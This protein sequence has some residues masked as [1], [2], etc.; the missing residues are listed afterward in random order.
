MQDTMTAEELA[1]LDRQNREAEQHPGGPKEYWREQY[2]GDL[3]GLDRHPMTDADFE[4]KWEDQGETIYIVGSNGLDGADEFAG[5]HWIAEVINVRGLLYRTAWMILSPMEFAFPKDCAEEFE[6][7]EDHPGGAREY[8]R[9]RM[10]G[11]VVSERDGHV[12]TAEEYDAVWNTHEEFSAQYSDLHGDAM[13]HDRAEDDRMIEHWTK[14]RQHPEGLKG[15]YREKALAEGKTPEEFEERWAKEGT[16]ELDDDELDDDEVG[17][18][19]VS[20]TDDDGHAIQA[21]VTPIEFPFLGT[22]EGDLDAPGKMSSRFRDAMAHP[23][24]AREYWRDKMVGKSVSDRDGHVMTS[25]EYDAAWDAAEAV[26]AADKAEHDRLN[27]EAQRDPRGPKEFW[28]ERVVGIEPYG[29]DDHPMTD[30]EFEAEWAERE[31]EARLADQAEFEAELEQMNEEAYR[32]P[33]GPKEY[34]REK[35]VGHD[36]YGADQHVM[37]NEDFEH[38]WNGGRG[39]IVSHDPAEPNWW[40]IKVDD[41]VFDVGLRDT[42]EISAVTEISLDDEGRAEGLGDIDESD[43]SELWAEITYA[44]RVRKVWQAYNEPAAEQAQS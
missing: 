1:E 33:R 2:K 41:R 39:F 36:H 18:A 5:Y 16:G 27:E 15:Y 31:R 3:Y 26:A 44:V 37:T 34:W 25:A 13:T 11:V 7:V 4:R 22:M 40:R 28:R 20:W 6:N 35:S 8:W 42:G 24:G 32:D 17:F 12:M 14:A 19:A 29:E 30:E 43:N 23:G 10:V 21:I 38:N 9:P